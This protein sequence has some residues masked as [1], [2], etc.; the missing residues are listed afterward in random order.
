[1]SAVKLTVKS[2]HPSSFRKCVE[3]RGSV[4]GS[5]ICTGCLAGHA[6]HVSYRYV[7]RQGE[8]G[9]NCAIDGRR[10]CLCRYLT[11]SRE[12]LEH[13]RKH[14]HWK[15][16]AFSW[17]CKDILYHYAQMWVSTIQSSRRPFRHR[18]QVSLAIF[19]ILS[20]ANA[21]L[22]ASKRTCTNNAPTNSSSHTARTER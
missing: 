14:C 15:N 12:H 18:K 4:F 20:L 3:M 16:L 13:L 1:V 21:A 17:I 5:R 7:L 2:A 10:K 6:S 9:G 11:K 8:L 22:A 19:C